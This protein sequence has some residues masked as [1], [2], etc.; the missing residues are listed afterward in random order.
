MQTWQAIGSAYS[1]TEEA[2]GRKR[3]GGHEPA[4]VP[5]EPNLPAAVCRPPSEIA[6]DATIV[7][8]GLVEIVGTIGIG[9][10]VILLCVV[11]LPGEIPIADAG[12]DLVAHDREHGGAA[13]VPLAAVMI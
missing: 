1:I 9:Q 8:N 2:A 4:A 6:M 12:R 3:S 7:R 13:K 10:A 5:A 11:A